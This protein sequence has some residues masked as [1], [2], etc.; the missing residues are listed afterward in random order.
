M[1]YAR[2]IT[3]PDN[4]NYIIMKLNSYGFDAFAVGG[5]VRDSILGRIPNDWDITTNALPEDIKN[6]FERTY[7]TG[8][9][10]G[11][12]SVGIEDA[13]IEVTTYR[14]DGE[15]SD[16][17]RPDSVRFTSSLRED[18]ARRDF[19]VNSIAY[20]PEKGIID[21]F[22]GLK[23]LENCRIRAV[24][25]ASLR[26]REDALRML[27]AVRFSA[28]L[29]FGIEKST[30]ASIKG[31]AGL[32]V[33]ISNERIRDE[34][35]KILVSQNPMHF[36]CLY[37]TGLLKYIM[38]EFMIC[39]ETGQNNPYHVYNVASHILHTVKYVKNTSILRWTMLL[40]DIGKPA[41]KTTDD[42]GID[43]FYGHQ[44]AS[45]DIAGNILNRL[46]FDKDSIKKIVRL[47]VYH[48][49]D[50]SDNEKA[51]RKLIGKVGEASFLDLTEVQRA[52]AMGQNREYLEKRLL[53]LEN[54]VNIY[55]K[56]MGDKHC[57]SKK[58]MAVNGHDLMAIGMEP[59]KELN[60]MLNYLL[61]C[62]LDSPELNNKQK[63]TEIAKNKMG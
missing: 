29:G 48:D 46:R 24:G 19:T 53:Q 9:K 27:R 16:N 26:F 3:F 51:I 2:Q 20:H 10:H 1:N 63:L 61:D 55:N 45:A 44:K 4:V 42:N 6:I 41:Q 8:I 38:P 31:N 56:I 50:I 37:H 39:Y 28:Q 62:V 17:R 21:F 18:L 23:D 52:D 30:Y 57:L 25:D 36:D 15:Y 11:T 33:N 54:I 12:V 60:N 40:H 13:H 34:L 7:D 58:D 22:E 14:I 49:T 43:H 32:I 47:I 35:N 5:C 59:G